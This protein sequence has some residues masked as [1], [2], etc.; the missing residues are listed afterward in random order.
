MHVSKAE[1]TLCKDKIPGWAIALIVI[2]CLLCVLFSRA[3]MYSREK[4]G[5]PMFMTSGEQ[6]RAAARQQAPRASS[7]ASR[8]EKEIQLSRRERARASKVTRTV[9]S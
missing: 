8:S 5:K 6:G 4:Q 1:E 3:G 9:S 7:R 2:A